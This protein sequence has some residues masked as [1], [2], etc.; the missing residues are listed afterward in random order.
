MDCYEVQKGISYLNSRLEEAGDVEL[1]RPLLVRVVALL[2]A[3]EEA[4]WSWGALVGR[5]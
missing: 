2:D 4:Q 3:A 5:R 1:Q